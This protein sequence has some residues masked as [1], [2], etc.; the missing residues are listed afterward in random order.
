MSLWRE[1]LMLQ[2][3]YV[4]PDSVSDADELPLF[5]RSRSP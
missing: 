1:P 5:M 2:K 4:P 3:T